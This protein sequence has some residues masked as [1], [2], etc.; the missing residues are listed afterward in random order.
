MTGLFG[1][2]LALGCRAVSMLRR[3]MKRVG[4]YTPPQFSGSDEY[5]LGQFP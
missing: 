3:R 5:Q 2:R 4:T 1:S